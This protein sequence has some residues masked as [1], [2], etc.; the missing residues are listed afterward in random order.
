MSLRPSL[1]ITD[2][3]TGFQSGRSS[4]EVRN[5]ALSGVMSMGDCLGPLQ[6]GKYVP[7]LLGPLLMP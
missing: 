4:L 2:P 3:P 7:H 5:D 1:W 6:S